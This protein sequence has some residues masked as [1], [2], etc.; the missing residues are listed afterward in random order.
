MLYEVRPK[1]RKT[2]PTVAGQTGGASPEVKPRAV[3]IVAIAS[4][5]PSSDTL[6]TPLQS[7]RGAGSSSNL[8]IK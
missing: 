5:G 3:G 8:I 2:G 4:S 6:C 1:L 7:S